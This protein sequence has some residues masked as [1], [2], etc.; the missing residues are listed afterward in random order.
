MPVTK[1][2]AKGA[3]GVIRTGGPPVTGMAMTGA[4]DIRGVEGMLEEGVVL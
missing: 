4:E 2:P 3:V 1:P